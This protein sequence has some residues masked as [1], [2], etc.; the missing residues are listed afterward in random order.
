MGLPAPD[1]PGAG[2]LHPAIT[3]RAEAEALL[4]RLQPSAAGAMH[5]L[6]RP[7][8]GAERSFAVSTMAKG[9]ISH[10]KLDQPAEG[11][12][13]V[14]NGKPVTSGK[15]L[16]DA[17]EVVVEQLGRKAGCPALTV[18]VMAAVGTDC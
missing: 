12:P 14:T 3:G 7:R 4:L 1:A 10:Q 15:R 2:W 16:T 6:V 18:P 17:T 11:G 8:A 9:R 5:Y 13:W